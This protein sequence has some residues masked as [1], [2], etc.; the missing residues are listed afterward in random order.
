MGGTTLDEQSRVGASSAE[1]A[2]SAHLARAAIVARF[3]ARAPSGNQ[4]SERCTRFFAW[5]MGVKADFRP[6][7]EDIAIAGVTERRNFDAIL[8][9]AQK[10]PDQWVAQRRFETAPLETERG[11]RFVCR[12][13]SPS[14][15]EPPA[16][17]GRVATKPLIDQ[18]AQDAAVLV[19]R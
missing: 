11:P 16:R 2:I 10:H 4:M 5:R 9:T 6:R 15:A 14:M 19:R 13:F 17:T 8:R 12:E 1:Q 7:G 18:E 3:L